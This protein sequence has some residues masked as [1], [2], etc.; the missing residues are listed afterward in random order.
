MQ[1]KYQTWHNW[2]WVLSTHEQIRGKNYMQS[3]AWISIFSSSK[4]L[5]SDTAKFAE[6][7]LKTIWPPT[8][9]NIKLAAGE[10]T[11]AKQAWLF[12]R[13]WRDLGHTWYICKAKLKFQNNQAQN[14][15]EVIQ[16]NLLVF[17]KNNLAPNSTK[18]KTGC[19][20]SDCGKTVLFWRWV[21][22]ILTQEQIQSK[23]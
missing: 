10:V 16:Q 13:S 21:F 8:L 20:G 14:G 12:S 3:Q 4:R 5:R 17:V 22:L 19:W 15:W 1:P 11:V 6:C 7:S 9:R 18:H 2:M 23:H